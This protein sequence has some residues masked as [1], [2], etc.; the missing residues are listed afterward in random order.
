MPKRHRQ[1][2]PIDIGGAASVH[3]SG[4]HARDAVVSSTP[5]PTTRAGPGHSSGERQLAE[6]ARRSPVDLPA[7]PQSLTRHRRQMEVHAKRRRRVSLDKD[8]Q[9]LADV[10]VSDDVAQTTPRE[11]QRRLTRGADAPDSTS[12]SGSSG[13]D[14]EEDDFSSAD[15]AGN[16]GNQL[17]SDGDSAS[18]D[19]EVELRRLRRA[20]AAA[21]AAAVA[22]S[23]RPRH[24]AHGAAARGHRD[25]ESEEDEEEEG[26][27]SS[28][29]NGALGLG[30]SDVDGSTGDE[31]TASEAGAG[32]EEEEEDDDGGH[33]TVDFGVFD[34]EASNVDG[35]LHLMDQLCPDKMNEV[36]RDVLGEA[37]LESPFTSVVRLHS[38]GED[39]TGEEAEEFYGLSSVL[40]V[41]H[42]VALYPAA[43]GALFELLQMQVWRQAASGIPPTEILTSVVEGRGGGAVSSSRAKCLLL[44]SEYIRNVPLEVTVQTLS[45]VLDR[46]DEV[47]EQERRTTVT[48]P[49]SATRERPVYATHPSMFAVLAKVQR[50]T[51]AP[52]TL[53]KQSAASGS[54]SGG[55][56][57]AR[58]GARS[59]DGGGGG[60]AGAGG[61]PPSLLDLTHYIFWREED[62]ILYDY[63]DTRVATLVYRCRPQYDGQP[64]HEIPLSLLFVLQYGAARQAV[65]EM[66]RRQT[67]T[68][69]VERY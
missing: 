65:E 38:N 37:L 22:A 60:G 26:S 44:V 14:G 59:G 67:A 2:E 32:E 20:M 33:V 42:G 55:P 53:P 21:A 41:A 45:D 51:D 63:R 3:G 34:M 10:P 31:E 6:Q 43:L 46:L 68:A 66:R 28:D 4:S 9:P 47:G 52:V 24:T 5:L 23:A 18:E 7:T 62:S 48:E 19:E 57:A 8:G 64:E 69:A 49:C 30:E 35:V 40:D 54:G 29:V 12:G 25:E 27:D 1:P 15:Y 56:S 17:S 61:M 11:Q 58:K 16:D 36:D 50:A 13:V 39:A